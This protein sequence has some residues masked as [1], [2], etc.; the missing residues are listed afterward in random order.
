[1]KIIKLV[2]IVVMSGLVAFAAQPAGHPL[3]LQW[4][5]KAI[6]KSNDGQF[7]IEVHPILTDPEN[8]SPVVVRRLSDKKEWR[9]FTLTRAARVMWS[10]D[11]HS[12]LV[13]DEPTADDFTVHLYSPEGKRTE[14]NTDR[15]MRSTV[16]GRLGAGREIEFYLPT[17]VSWKDSELV[18]AV[19]GT[20]S[21]GM[22]SPMESLPMESFCF[23][24]SVDSGSGKVLSAKKLPDSH[25]R[26]SP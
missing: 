11:S 1:M 7:Q 6:L 12:I 3:F 23:A 24:V 22:P 5:K 17:F 18:I 14:V 16:A 21:T 8:H 19:G 20:S 15:L 4:S 13:I 25:C 9:L 2:L 26:L 10:S